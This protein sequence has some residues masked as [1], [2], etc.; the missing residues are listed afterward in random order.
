MKYLLTTASLLAMTSTAALAITY[1]TFEFDAGASSIAFSQNGSLCLGCSVN[2]EF[3]DVAPW[4]P[5]SANE[6]NVVNNFIDWDIGGL[7]AESYD[8]EA[9][10]AF[11][12]PDAAS[13]S[14]D[15]YGAYWTIYG[16][17]SGGVLSWDGPGTIDFAQGSSVD[18]YLEGGDFKGWGSSVTT[19]ITFV[20]NDIAPVPLP[21][22]AP[23]LLAGIGAF[24]FAGRR[25]KKKAAA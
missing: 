19:G 17:V 23:L 7:G 25:R 13:G 14:T 20:G 8:L 22:A 15:G 9:T 6:V 3:N 21:A 24:G 5:T 16:I 11:S 2:Y 12:T 1:P 4:T 18:F 10:I